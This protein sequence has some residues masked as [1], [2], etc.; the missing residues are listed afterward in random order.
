MRVYTLEIYACGSPVQS[1]GHQRSVEH[2]DVLFFIISLLQL[3]KLQPLITKA[4]KK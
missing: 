4:V 2:S 3:W 1:R